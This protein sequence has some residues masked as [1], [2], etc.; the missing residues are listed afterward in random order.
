M[1]KKYQIFVSSTFEDL[2]DERRAVIEAILDL[3]HIPIGMEAFQ[4]SNE[5]QWSYIKK[6]IDEADYYIIIVAE[7]YGSTADDGRSYT[8]MEY[9]YAREKGVPVA[10]FLLHDEART[11]WR[12]EKADSID[13]RKKIDL[14]RKK[15]QGL[16][17]KFWRNKDD[18]AAACTKSISHLMSNFPRDGWIPAKDAIRP[19]VANEFARLTEENHSIKQKLDEMLKSA[20]SSNDDNIILNVMKNTF[21][22]ITE[23]SFIGPPTPQGRKSID[24]PI[25]LDT[26]FYKVSYYD[27]IVS[28]RQ[29]FVHGMTPHNIE[30]KLSNAVET[31]FRNDISAAKDINPEIRGIS[32]RFSGINDLLTE[33][34]FFSIGQKGRRND[35]LGEVVFLTEK[36][37][38][39]IIRSSHIV[40]TAESNKQDLP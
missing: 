3:G 2:K 26:S 33:M 24:S 10:A 17:V 1:N 28:L 4:A 6:R 8:E 27:V 37:K 40:N 31:L 18:L 32:F 25:E 35:L 7:R 23:Y 30:S 9:D 16:L 36:G 12:R 5:E 38:S 19:E 20:S 15:C 34:E 39:F 11:E 29:G 13:D 22:T 14:F 21:L